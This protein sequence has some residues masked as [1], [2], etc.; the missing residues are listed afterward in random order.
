MVA[1]KANMLE[2]TYAKG[3]K[4]LDFDLINPFIDHFCFYLDFRFSSSSSI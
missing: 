2:G 1:H 4:I 3:M